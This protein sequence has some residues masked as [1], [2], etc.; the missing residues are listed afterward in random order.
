[1][2]ELLHTLWIPLHVKQNRTKSH[3][4]Y[5]G[6]RE[7]RVRIGTPVPVVLE[8]QLDGSQFGNFLSRLRC[9]RPALVQGFVGSV[10]EAARRAITLIQKRPRRLRRNCWRSGRPAA[11]AQLGPHSSA[12]VSGRR[13][14]TFVACQRHALLGH[15]SDRYSPPRTF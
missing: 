5:V 3:T 11:V 7:R 14:R 12:G 9:C 1:M 6:F 8:V 15:L 13:I 2:T 4:N 10:E